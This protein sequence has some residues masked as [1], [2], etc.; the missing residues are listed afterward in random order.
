M[1]ATTAE[2]EPARAPFGGAA[3]PAGRR[4]RRDPRPGLRRPGRT[5]S[6]LHREH[7]RD[8]APPRRD[9]P[10]AAARRP[11]PP[12]PDR[13]HG[14]ALDGEDPREHGDRPQRPARA[15]GLDERSPDQL[16]D[17]GLGHGLDRRGLEALAQLRPPHLHQ[18]P[19]QGQGPGLRDHA[20]RSAAEMAPGLPLPAA[21][22]PR[23]D[24]LLRVGGGAP[25]SRLRGDPHGREVEGP[26]QARA[27]RNSRAR[28]KARSSRTT[29]P[30][31][32]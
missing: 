27:G 3:R 14:G 19:W 9:R 29:S 28:R 13:R 18:H 15:V 2:V 31:R 30:G 4:A 17:L 7:D 8:A 12:R 22:Q 5:R 11:L 25:R 26:G 32:C 23:A 24:G 1:N 16:L 10:R 20:H 6:P 21:L